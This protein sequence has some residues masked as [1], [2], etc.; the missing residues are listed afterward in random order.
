MIDRT[1]NSPMPRPAA[2]ALM[3]SATATARTPMFT[4]MYE[5]TMSLRWCLGR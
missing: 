2:V 4:V 3:D 5:T 1:P